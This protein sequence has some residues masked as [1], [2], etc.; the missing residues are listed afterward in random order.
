MNPEI[1]IFVISLEDAASRRDPLLAQLAEFRLQ[2]RVFRAIDGRNGLSSEFEG[3]IDRDG[4]LINL[5]R[6][7][8][9]VEYACALSHVGVYRL[10]LSLGLKGAIVLE[11][12]ASLEPGFATLL[13]R[14]DLKRLDMLFFNYG[15]AR[16]WRFGGEPVEGTGYSLLRL[17]HNTGLASGY[18]ISARGA[19]FVLDNGLPVS[20]PA[21]WLCDLRALKP[22]VVYPRVV[23]DGW[24][25]SYLEEARANAKKMRAN[26]NAFRGIKSNGW[27]RGRKRNPVPWHFRWLSR[28]FVS[29]IRRRSG[30]PWS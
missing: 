5:G 6:P 26:G 4:A 1:P 12:D 18:Y 3:S 13:G 25:G 17:V 20:L 27:F 7:L 24:R 29:N 11:D 2:Y 30:A 22:R 21:D 14:M 16:V 28:I 19:E 15:H 23:S 10:I 8:A 9:D